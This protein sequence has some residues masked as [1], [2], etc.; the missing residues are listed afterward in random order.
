MAASISPSLYHRMRGLLFPYRFSCVVI[1]FFI[2]FFGAVYGNAKRG[3]EKSL[4][5]E[6]ERVDKVCEQRVNRIEKWM[7][8]MWRNGWTRAIDE[9]QR[10]VWVFVT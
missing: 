1:T 9:K 7:D 5:R 8:Y 2:Y 6:R 10:E 3:R 4:G